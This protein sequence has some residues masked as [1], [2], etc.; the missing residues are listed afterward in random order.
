MRALVV[1]LAFA[2]AVSGGAVAQQVCDAP[3][4]GRSSPSTR[5]LDGADGTVTDKDTKL[6]WM[7]CSAGQVGPGCSGEA[8]RFDWAAAQSAAAD[9]NRLG[10]YFYSDWRLPQLRELA[11][12]AERQCANPRV[13]LTVFPQTPADLYWTT[14]LRPATGNK[15][16]VFALGFG[17][18]GIKYLAKED[19]AYLRLVRTAQ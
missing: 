3:P 2:A 19:T 17:V 18:D 6:M 1:G 14:T 5:F 8:S 9:V 15:S 4:E 13:N 12:I 10:T 16:F 7:R 11:T